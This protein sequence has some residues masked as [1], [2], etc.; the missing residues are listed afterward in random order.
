ML[1]T[2]RHIYIVVVTCP[3][4]LVPTE[5]AMQTLGSTLVFFNSVQSFGPWWDNDCK[6]IVYRADY[7]MRKGA[8][9]LS[10]LRRALCEGMS[11]EFRHQFMD[12]DT[13]MQMR[14]ELRM[15]ELER[16]ASRLKKTEEENARLKASLCE[17]EALV[18]RDWLAEVAEYDRTLTE[19]LALNGRIKGQLRCISEAIYQKQE[20]EMRRYSFGRKAKSH[21]LAGPRMGMKMERL[22]RTSDEE[23]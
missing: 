8:W 17:S 3:N 7:V 9:M 4:L 21:G 6:S 18:Q 1:D 15:T 19:A 10:D 22:Q 20:I 2:P 16:V 14:Q 13:I 23:K 5:L 12:V 11:G